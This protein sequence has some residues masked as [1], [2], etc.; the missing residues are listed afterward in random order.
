MGYYINPSDETKEEWLN[1][2][3]IE[4]TNPSWDALPN[5]RPTEFQG[6]DGVYVCLVDNGPFTAA[7]VCYNEQEF[8][9]FNR[10]DEPRPRK[11]YVVSREDI[12]NVCPDVE[13]RLEDTLPK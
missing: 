11:W 10:D 13:D 6:D 4:V 2:N 7:A 9:E 12:I 5:F 3:G 1:N 8:D